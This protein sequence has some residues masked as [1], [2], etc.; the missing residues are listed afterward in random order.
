MDETVEKLT[1]YVLPLSE[2]L[3]RDGNANDRPLLTKR[4]AAAAK[5][6]AN[7]HRSK[8][9][10]SMQSLV[11]QEQH[12]HGWSFITGPSGKDI[13]EKWVAFAD[14]TGLGQ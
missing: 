9:V 6:Y 3:A 8:S 7:L 12:G 2:A 10:A 11:Q 4:L 13:T 14:V 5:M 1:D